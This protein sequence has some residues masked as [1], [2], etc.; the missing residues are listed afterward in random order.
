[1]INWLKNSL[2]ITMVMLYMAP[3]NAFAA[4]Q[5]DTID[6]LS[7]VLEKIQNVLYGTG[8]LVI[9]VAIM[10]AGY[11]LAFS[12]SSLQD[13]AKPFLGA[14]L[15]GAAAGIAGAIIDAGL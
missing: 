13:V 9:T 8:V 11:K 10:W 6:S 5:K 14:I 12:H 3:V 1:M 2:A 4:L 15:I 7:K